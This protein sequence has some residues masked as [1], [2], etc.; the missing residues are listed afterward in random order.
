M[1]FPAGGA[2][3]VGVIPAVDAASLVVVPLVAD[4][5]TLLGAEPVEAPETRAEAAA[6]AGALEPVV[7]LTVVAPELAAA[8]VDVPEDVTARVE[9]VE[10]NVV[11]SVEKWVVKTDVVQ[12]DEGT[13]SEQRSLPAWSFGP[14]NMALAI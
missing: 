4:G 10:T 8:L 7:P 12:V 14:D 3:T 13:N 5:A 2:E 9:R 11:P 1:R 6:D